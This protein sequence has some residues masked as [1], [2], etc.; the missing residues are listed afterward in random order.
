MLKDKD[1]AK[2]LLGSVE[3]VFTPPIRGPKLGLE[4]RLHTEASSNVF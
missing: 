1:K 4:K 3:G 2:E